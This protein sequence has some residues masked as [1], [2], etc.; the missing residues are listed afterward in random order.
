MVNI[1]DYDEVLDDDN[2]PFEKYDFN[3]FVGGHNDNSFVL[4]EGDI[5]Y[6]LFN[7][8][9]YNPN[10]SYVTYLNDFIKRYYDGEEL[11]ISNISCFKKD[12]DYGFIEHTVSRLANELGIPTQYSI[13]ISGDS[14]EERRNKIVEF[15]N[16]K[17]NTAKLKINTGYL[18]SVDFIGKNERFETIES[19]LRKDKRSINDLNN[20]IDG[21]YLRKW[22][23]EM[24]IRSD[25]DFVNPFNNEALSIDIRKRLFGEFLP[26]YFF[27]KYIVRDADLASSN[28]GIIFNTETGEY[29]ISPMYDGEYCFHGYSK[30]TQD[31]KERIQLRLQDE[32]T[33]AY[34]LYPEIMEEFITKIWDLYHSNT[35]N[36][37]WMDIN[38]YGLIPDYKK[39]IFECLDNFVDAV[40]CL[41]LGRGLS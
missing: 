8:I 12:V 24:I 19:Y 29:K 35:I 31:Q 37:E 34:R 7:E 40:N 5:F 15:L 38:A 30:L 3:E 1:R 17:A 16:S 32:L 10:C 14:V 20:V 23:A 18:L 25:E 39:Y 9:K 28:V 13:Y 26:Q 6:Q 22:Y 41:N 33:F 11:P 36:D 27:K 4:C 2:K 21:D